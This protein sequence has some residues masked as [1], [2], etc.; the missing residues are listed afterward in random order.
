MIVWLEP[1][2]VARLS[3]LD[4]AEGGSTAE[5]LDADLAA[6]VRR[7][8]VMRRLFYTAVLAVALYGTAT[9][10]VAQF[11]LPWPVAIGSIFALELGGV[12]F[13]SNAETRRRLGEHA[14]ISRL[15]GAVV[16]GAAAAF[17]LLTHASVLLGGFFALMSVLGF[18]AWWLDVENKRRDWLRA[19]GQLAAP[20]PSYE[21]W[22]H[23]LRHPLVTRRARG[24]ARAYPQLGLYGS[25]E[26]ALI[27][28]R[29]E[30]RNAALA[31]TLRQRIRA[32]VGKNLADIAVLTFDMDEV[33]DRLRG[34][35]DYDGLTALLSSELTAERVLH[36]RDDRAAQ[37]ARTWL[38]EH[39]NGLSLPGQH[40]DNDER[41]VRPARS[42]PA[43]PLRHQTSQADSV[44]STGAV[45]L[46]SSERPAAHV[47]GRAPHVSSAAA[48]LPAVRIGDRN[49]V[50]VSLDHI[51]LDPPG[52]RQPA[53][54]VRH[55]DQED[56]GVTSG[57][58][59]PAEDDRADAAAVRVQVLGGPA[60]LDPDG[61]PVRGLRS[62]SVELLVYLA[63][64]RDGATQAEIVEDVW[65]D[66]APDRAGQRLSTC[67]ANLRGVI[68]HVHE[69]RDGDGGD[70]DTRVVPV[71]YLGSRY[72]LDPAIVTVDWWRIVDRYAQT[73][74]T[75]TDRSDLAQ[76]VAGI[77]VGSDYPWIEAA[78]EQAYRDL[79][80]I[81]RRG[82]DR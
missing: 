66:V 55:D 62:K 31:H 2:L 54:T 13:L 59:R 70:G 24:F 36:G 61:R 51:R 25:L 79:D 49:D 1:D 16:A 41:P 37:A 58:G 44:G 48:G 53:T 20:T 82:P 78:R 10:A 77:A 39:R 11:G 19:R 38:A 60:L 3:H 18:L 50:T 45:D 4:G 30:R 27:T 46:P 14:A 29:R 8:A 47:N 75:A 23:W 43:A 56:D 52:G 69:S 42:L 6:A 9:G 81:D 65:P 64:H 76:T 68:R 80:P 17:N 15:L 28:I 71:L 40:P 7:T 74:E 73:A 63:V 22:E 67:L 33:A 72:R 12:V 5:A 35:A 32:A 57:A 26:A 34:G 21:L